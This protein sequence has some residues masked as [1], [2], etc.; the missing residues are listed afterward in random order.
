MTN[1]KDNDFLNGVPELLILR[2]LARQPMYGY[3][4]VQTIRLTSDDVLAFG[5][6]CIYPILHRLESE[7]CLASRR[8]EVAGRNRV[9]YRLTQAGR[10]RLET[11]TARWEGITAAVG[12]LLGGGSDGSPFMA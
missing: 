10:K 9:V 7:G 2:L 3:E 4:L 11:A 12:R 6:G 8:E 5:E 1:R